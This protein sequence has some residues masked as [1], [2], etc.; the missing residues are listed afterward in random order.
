MV[1]KDWKKVRKDAWEHKINENQIWI[2]GY[3]LN[4][5]EK[6]AVLITEGFPRKPKII[7][8]FKTKQQA[9]KFAKSYMR[10]H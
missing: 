3:G 5:I 7:R 4:Y 6:Y 1:L 10:T 2:T 8:D 9:L